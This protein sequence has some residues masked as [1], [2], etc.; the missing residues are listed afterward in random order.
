[1]ILDLFLRGCDKCATLYWFCTKC[2]QNC[3][4]ILICKVYKLLYF[5]YFYLSAP[6]VSKFCPFTAA[7]FLHKLHNFYKLLKIQWDKNVYMYN[8]RYAVYLHYIHFKISLSSCICHP[9][10]FLFIFLLNCKLCQF[11]LCALWINTYY[12]LWYFLSF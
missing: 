4:Y 3:N 6:S 11:L 2:T 10:F 9:N 8:C 7:N 5:Y 12:P 1:M